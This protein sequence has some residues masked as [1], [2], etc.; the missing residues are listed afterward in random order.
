MK[1]FWLIAISLV[2]VFFSAFFTWQW[3]NDIR[4]IRHRQWLPASTPLEYDFQ[5]SSIWNNHRVYLAS[6]GHYGIRTYFWS[7]VGRFLLAKEYE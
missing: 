3:T 4:F 6:G 5:S 1:Y 2:L 7:S